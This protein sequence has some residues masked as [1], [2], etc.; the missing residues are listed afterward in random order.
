MSRLVDLWLEIPEQR[1]NRLVLI[2][3]LFCLIAGIFWAARNVLFPFIVGLVVAY[4]LAP[5]INWI[6]RGFEWLGSRNLWFFMKG[7]FSR[8]AEQ[9][10]QPF[11][12][13]LGQ[14]LLDRR[15]LGLLK[16]WARPFSILAAYLLV[17]ALL[18]G[19]FALFVPMVIEQ[20]GNLWNARMSIWDAVTRFGQG[21]MEQYRL[22]PP[23]IRT[24]V[25]ANLTKLNSYIADLVPKAATGTAGALSFTLGALTYTI[26]LVFGFFIVPFWTF[27]LLK[28]AGDL[29][30][31]AL[32]LIPATLRDDLMHL[33]K[34]IDGVLASYLRGQLILGV[35]IGVATAIG[36]TFL[37][38]PYALLLGVV[39]AGFEL[40]PNIGPFLGAVP[41]IM[42]TL[43]YAPQQ[44]W[45]VIIFAILIQQLENLFIT[46]RVLGDSVSLHPVLIMVV[47]V[48]GSE[49]GGLLG[50]Y[51]AP[52]ATAVIRDSF[53]YFYYRFS[54][55]GM[56]PQQALERVQKREKIDISV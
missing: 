45:P 13:K 19:F 51:L 11:Q 12:Q 2:V 48:V 53:R 22:L 9:S 31:S 4:L 14:W 41:T 44:I 16:K 39:A 10:D 27:Y 5:L 34:L 24:Q 23:D 47:L 52:L 43:A 15:G 21:L 46:P 1:R 32:D 3:L 37:G 28:D 18:V 38:V 55:E 50:L 56:T 26:S 25:E 17:V 35:I 8:L 54:D 20:A 6:Q 29:Q 7:P 49:I 30:D 40:I 42:V 33:L 36:L